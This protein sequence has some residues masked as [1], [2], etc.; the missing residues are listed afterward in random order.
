MA[1]IRVVTTFVGLAAA[2][3]APWGPKWP[4][5]NGQGDASGINVQLGPRPFY[6]VDNM[7]EGPLKDKLQSCSQVTSKARSFKRLT[8]G[9]EGTLLNIKLL[10]FAS[11]CSSNVS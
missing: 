5:H 2:L 4:H 11:R 10:D 9:E 6:L 1:S 7:D 8:K 3:P